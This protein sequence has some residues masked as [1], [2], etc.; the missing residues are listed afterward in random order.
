[1]DPYDTV[2][3]PHPP[4]TAERINRTNRARYAGLAGAM[5]LLVLL[6]L[7]VDFDADPDGDV[8][9]AEWESLTPEGRAGVCGDWGYNPNSAYLQWG[10]VMVYDH[11]HAHDDIPPFGATRDYIAGRC[12]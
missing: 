7:L 9:D 12:G 4:L 5:A 11:G 8:L 1:M 3:L 2:P 6:V 10:Y